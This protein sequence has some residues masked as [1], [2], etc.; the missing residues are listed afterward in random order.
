MNKTIAISQFKAEED[1]EKNIKKAESFIKEAAS[2]GAELVIFPEMSFDLFFP[3]HRA[4]KRFFDL[5]EPV[6]GPLVDRFCDIAKKNST[7]VVFNMFES[8]RAGE[9][10]DCSPVIDKNGNYLGKSRMMHIAELPDYNEKYYYWEGD[11]GYPVF[12]LDGFRIGIAICYDRHFPEQMRTL[13][14]KGADLIV[15]PTATSLTELKNIWEVEMQAAAVANQI[16]I[17]VS[18]R[19]G[20]EVNLKFFGKSFTVNPMGDVIALASE[21]KEEVLLFDINSRVIKE[22]RHLLPFLRDRRPDTYGGLTQKT[23]W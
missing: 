20:K 3:Q 6:P 4:D 23:L 18:N 7:A 2:K 5:A 10:Y 12:D 22:A 11:S 21:N 17:A 19:V 15:V 9:Y 14:L 1:R 13:T 8:G 16:Y